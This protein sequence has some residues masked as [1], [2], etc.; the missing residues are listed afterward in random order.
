M[1]SRRKITAR[2]GKPKVDSSESD[3]E[4]EEEE[5]GM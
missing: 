1:T 2:R 5:K 3:E 4:E